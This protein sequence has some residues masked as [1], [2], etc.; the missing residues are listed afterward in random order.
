M[1]VTCKKSIVILLTCLITGAAFIAPVFGAEDCSAGELFDLINKNEISMIISY[2]ELLKHTKDPF[3]IGGY[4]NAGFL[5]DNHYFGLS[6]TRKGATRSS[7]KIDSNMTKT[8][9]SR[10]FFIP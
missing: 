10:A 9:A 3:L 2:E 5:T 4:L 8:L 6:Y 7:D 1:M